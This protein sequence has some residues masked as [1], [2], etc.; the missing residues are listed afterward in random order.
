MK[1][2]DTIIAQDRSFVGT[3]IHQ[4]G[5]KHEIL[6]RHPN[7]T[8]E[9]KLLDRTE[10]KQYEP[11]TDDDAQKFFAVQ[12]EFITDSIKRFFESVLPNFPY[13]LQVDESDINLDGVS[14]LPTTI[15][16]PSIGRIKEFP[17]F[18]LTDWKY[19]FATRDFPEDV[20]D[21]PVS[22][23][24]SPQEAASALVQY[25]LAKHAA[26]WFEQEAEA[27]FYREMDQIDADN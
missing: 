9:Q 10:F 12:K 16:V 22:E 13:Q 4:T 26:N 6:V 18:Q 14:L 5:D 25:V 21:I 1:Q 11:I 27:A 8:T 20:S 2:N 19:H 24:R 3:Y 7:G 23:H 17:G 15:E